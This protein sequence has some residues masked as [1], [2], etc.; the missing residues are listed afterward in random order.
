VIKKRIDKAHIKGGDERITREGTITIIYSKV[1][2]EE[3]YRH[4]I[5]ILQSAGLLTE[6]IDHF[7]VEDLQGV[8]GL[9]GLRVGVSYGKTHFMSQ[10][11]TYDAI[12]KQLNRSLSLKIAGS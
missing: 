7:E 9:K 5:Q 11:F 10:D 2:E 3:E 1:E 4:Y 6:T 12:Y 8:V